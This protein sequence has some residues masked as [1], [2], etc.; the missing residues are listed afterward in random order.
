MN[1]AVLD[2]APAKFS[3]NH[4][5]VA[6]KLMTDS[7]SFFRIGPE[8][9]DWQNQPQQSLYAAVVA[10]GSSGDTSQLVV[11]SVE[12]VMKQQPSDMPIVQR[13]GEAIRSAHQILVEA[14]S[15]RNELRGIS[16]TIVLAV[17]DGW[18]LN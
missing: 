12:R 17:I 8:E 10:D 3:L 7:H 18:H 4:A 6:G 5:G 14:S 13:M 11:Q 9:R 2:Q 15:N 1:L 16:A